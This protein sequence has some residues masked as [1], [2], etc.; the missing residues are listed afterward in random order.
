MVVSRLIGR[1]IGTQLLEWRTMYSYI[2]IIYTP[3]TQ[4]HTL[5]DE[6]PIDK[7][8]NIDYKSLPKS[9]F[10]SICLLIL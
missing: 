6:W 4:L 8:K 10:D 1:S 3:R 9:K 7:L 5:T 2:I